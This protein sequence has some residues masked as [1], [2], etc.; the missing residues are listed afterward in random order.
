VLAFA[1][2]AITTEATTTTQTNTV[3]DY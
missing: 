3:I 2:A 1:F